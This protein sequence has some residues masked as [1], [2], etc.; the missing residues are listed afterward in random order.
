MIPDNPA[1]L[2]TGAST[3]IGAACAELADAA[4]YRVFAGVRKKEDGDQLR[5]RCSERLEPI[6]LDVT[7]T[8]SIAAATELLHPCLE[9]QG[10]QALVNNAGIVVSGP[11][12]GVPMDRF[13]R[14]MEVNLF[15]AVAVTQSM[16]PLVRRGQG[17]IVQMSSISGRLTPPY[18][19][20]Y[21][22]SKY[23][24][25]AVS[26][27]L[28]LELKPWGIEVILIEP[29]SIATPIWEK[30]DRDAQQL[31][32]DFPPH[33][34]ELYAGIMSRF[35][36]A[37]AKIG[38]QGIPPENVARVVLRSLRAKKPKPRYLVGRDAKAGAFFNRILPA[39]AMDWLKTKL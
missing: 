18:A 17:R 8:A 39:R 33:V 9:E 28:R 34:A 13:R 30:I 3:G 15:G 11:M 35:R 6:R 31:D 23:A 22:A 2:I 21:A 25:E 1:I 32:D 14:Q 24:L 16:L 37:S 10:L 26:D 27:A 19:G 20:C 12:E 38:A 4:G 7:E 29:G 36:R 5:Q